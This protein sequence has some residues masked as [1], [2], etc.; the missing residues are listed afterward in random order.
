MRAFRRIARKVAVA[1]VLGWL[2]AL[3]SA[4]CIRA[5]GQDLE[6]AEPAQSNVDAG[7][8][9]RA[10]RWRVEVLQVLPHDRTAFT[11]GLVWQ[12]GALYESTGL[13][14]RSELRRV[15]RASGQ[16]QQRV[17]LE[18]NFFGEGLALV[19]DRLIMLT[20]QEHVARVFDR[21]FQ[22]VGE[23]SYPTEG[24]GL[25]YDGSRLVMS[26]GSSTLYFRD[27]TTFD[28]LG[29]V[30]VTLDG[31]PTE[32]LNELEC[33]GDWVYANVW[34]TDTI[35]R[36]DPATGQVHAVIDAS[37]LLAPSERPGTDVLNGI[38]YDPDQDVFLITGKLWP[39]LYEV[40]F[41]PA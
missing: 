28:V 33:V 17:A 35:V 3:G 15:D 29:S 20:W 8:G 14:G 22:V 31:Q 37:G 2:V 34:Q 30:L 24:W 32:M 26:D 13:R 40:R 9:E 6:Q 21:S 19:D 39:H 10:E 36:I 4:G 23:F 7:Q 27:P 5:L 18:P 25:C 12:D 41:V 16:V 38:A 11:Q 1:L